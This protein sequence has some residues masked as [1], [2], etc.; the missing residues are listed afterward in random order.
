MLAP[1]AQKFLERLKRS[2]AKPLN[3]QSYIEARTY[4]AA[5]AKLNHKKA[6]VDLKITDVILR[7]FPV[8]AEAGAIE[9]ALRFYRPVS[10]PASPLPPLIVY[11][12]GGGFVTGNCDYTDL[13]CQQTA[14]QSHS[15]VISVEYHLAPEYP[16]P[17]AIEEGASIIKT[18]FLHHEAYRFQQDSISLMGDSAGAN[19]AAVI[20]NQ[21][22]D[23]MALY[24]Q[25]LLYPVVDFAGQYPSHKEFGQNY[26][27]TKK[28]MDWSRQL[29]L[30]DLSQVENPLAS[31][32]LADN[33]THLPKTL[34]ITAGCDPLRDEGRA[35]AKR[36]IASGNAVSYFE[37]K[38]M[39]HCFMTFFNLFPGYSDKAL[40]EVCKFLK[41]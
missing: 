4:V 38:G 3:E 33:L 25:I 32:I 19:I 24:A 27:L 40:Q 35:Y 10:S 13:L 29:Y 28:M 5:Q 22:K 7:H 41:V 34:I 20:T 15:L 21:L 12:H 23:T 11:F 1:V 2:R 30:Q 37:Y 16:F 9:T 18:L 8:D 39:I 36:L 31:P 26:F 6:G 17:F 14:L